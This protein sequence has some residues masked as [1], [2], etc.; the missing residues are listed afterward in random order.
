MFSPSS[1]ESAETTTGVAAPWPRIESDLEITVL[2]GS[3]PCEE[4][5]ILKTLT[6]RNV[7]SLRHP[8][9]QVSLDR[10]Q[11][12]KTVFLAFVNNPP[13]PTPPDETFLIR[14]ARTSL[15]EDDITAEG[16]RLDGELAPQWHGD[17]SIG[18]KLLCLPDLLSSKQRRYRLFHRR[19]PAPQRHKV[20]MRLYALICVWGSG[21]TAQVQLSKL[22]CPVEKRQVNHF[23]K[24][25]SQDRVGNFIRFFQ[26]LLQN[27][28]S[29]S[30]FLAEWLTSLRQWPVS[31]VPAPNGPATIAC[32]RQPLVPVLLDRPAPVLLPPQF[33]Q[34]TQ[35]QSLQR[36][37]PLLVHSQQQKRKSA[38]LG[39]LS[40]WAFPD[41]DAMDD[42]P[43]WM[44]S[45]HPQALHEPL[46]ESH[47]TLPSD[48]V[49]GTDDLSS[50]MEINDLYCLD[51]PQPLES[52]SFDMMWS[53]DAYG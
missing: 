1:A 37:P 24:P 6:D 46:D 41:D 2:E 33:W 21:A 45:G 15:S 53:T 48:M 32:P 22:M 12:Q 18:Y 20:H 44:V 19:P 51:L 40:A 4:R 26:S 14:L 43:S 23:E 28:H 3:T 9:V 34:P 39:G 36:S 50:L 17:R 30:K 8:Y 29:D 5:C 7:D 42:E 35:H 16:V 52:L 47:M 31:G 10:S 27:L 11:L 49:Y 38:V 13:A 25:T